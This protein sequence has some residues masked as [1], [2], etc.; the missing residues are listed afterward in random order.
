ME[1]AKICIFFVIMIVVP[2]IV[3]A[4][5]MV[6]WKREY[7]MLERWNVGMLLMHG[8]FFVIELAGSYAGTSLKN[9]ALCYAA[10]LFLVVLWGCVFCVREKKWR[11]WQ[12]PHFSKEQREWFCVLLTIVVLAGVFYQ[13]FFVCTKLHI[14]DDDAYY[15][16]WAVDAYY[17]NVLSSHHPLTGLA[18]NI[19]E[20][21]DYV[22][23]PY[24][25]FW[26]MWS[27]VLKLHPAILMRS[28]LPAVTIAWCY[29]V[30]WLLAKRLFEKTEQRL[31][32]LLFVVLANYFGGYSNLSTSVF[33]FVRT[34]QGKSV[35]AAV[36]VPM[37]WYI[38]MKIRK[39]PK[40][41]ELWLYL[42]LA[43][44]ASCLCS[45]MA[46]FLGL[47]VLG[48]CGLEYLIEK[49]DWKTVGKLILCTIPYFLMGLC[50]VYLMYYA[51]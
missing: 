49:R 30:Y 10:A 51:S 37:L 7:G 17:T 6:S 47:L 45:T 31:E 42:A 44:W 2:Y 50:E 25:V 12:I 36:F 21:A 9:V 22:I 18:A 11:H 33:L 40:S 4:S 34:W 15:V 48:A 24:P 32:F 19:R 29:I 43:V 28:A 16:G 23:A 38:W 46:I 3:G 41:R 14:D 8:I 26:A 13:M 27:K 5:F 39:E 35:I 20:I 1:A